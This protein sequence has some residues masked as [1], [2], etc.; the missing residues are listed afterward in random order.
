MF[1]R[2]EEELVLKQVQVEVGE[3]SVQESRIRVRERM[4]FGPAMVL[5]W[6]QA[7]HRLKSHGEG[8]G[9]WRL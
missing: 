5:R 6:G 9:L 2:K 8:S 3:G 4:N 7:C 1:G